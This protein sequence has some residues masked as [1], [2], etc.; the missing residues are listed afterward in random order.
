MV[1]KRI[2]NIIIKYLNNQASIIE[3]EELENWL[4]Y[5]KNEKCFLEYVKINFLIDVNLKK[6]NTKHSEIKL[7]EFI[8]KQKKTQKIRKLKIVY[9]YAASIIIIFS[10]I[11]LYKQQITNAN[12][13][14][15]PKENITLKLGDGNIKVLDEG[16]NME[17]KDKDGNIIGTQNDDAIVYNDK[18][19]IN[20]IIYNTLTV[21]YGKRFALK[22][23]DGTKVNLNS[24]TTLRYPIKFIEGIKRE[25][26]I[27]EGEAYF[28]VAKDSKHPFIVNNNKMNVEV[29]GTQFNV[30]A[31]SEDKNITTVLVEGSVKLY[32]KNI[33]NSDKQE[34]LQP[35]YK[36]EWN[37][38]SQSID[39]SKADI[40]VHTAWI[41]GRIILKHMKFKNIIKKLERHYNVNIV[42]NDKLLSEE[43]ITATFDIETIE[44]VF[45]VINEIHSIDYKITNNQI[46]INNKNLMQMK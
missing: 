25:V 44:Q 7:L 35:G 18:N 30:S 15:I 6:F 38:N 3:L 13:P 16:G 29:L 2:E 34:V 37:K 36:A 26:F 14:I 39:I 43:Y 5:K 32:S 1:S 27:V 4:S 23:S 17:I 42:N 8:A 24:G 31:Y 45:E 21:P 9:K 22:L 46:T 28:N 11:Y 12:L 20:K 10:S 41:N 19:N 40:D 33:K